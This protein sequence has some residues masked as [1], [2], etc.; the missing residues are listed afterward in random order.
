VIPNGLDLADFVAH[1]TREEMRASFGLSD[2][3]VVVVSAGRLVDFK[4]FDVLLDAV[5]QLRPRFPHLKCVVV[6]EGPQESAL[7]QRALQGDLAGAVIFAGHRDD[8]AEVLVGCDVFVLTSP[9]E[10]FGRVLIEAMAMSLP[11]VTAN[12][13]GPA[14]IVIDA[15]TGVLVESNRV[16]AFAGALEQLCCDADSRRRFG[17]AGRARV[18]QHYSM[19]SHARGVMALYNDLLGRSGDAP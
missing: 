9:V 6:G 1:G 17:A 16:E 14:E 4:R 3:D 19:E 10:S 11:V 18:V 12:T 7:R 15:H 5:G 8:V 13:G 2:D